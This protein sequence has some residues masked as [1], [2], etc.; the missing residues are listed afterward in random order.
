[1]IHL[2]RCPR[3]AP[4]VLIARMAIWGFVRPAPGKFAKLQFEDSVVGL[5]NKNF[6]PGDE[7]RILE[8][9]EIPADECECHG[10]MMDI[11]RF[12]E[13]NP[14]AD[15]SRLGIVAYAS[16]PC[17]NCRTDAARLLLGQ[18]VAPGW[19]VDECRHDS[20]EEGRKLFAEITRHPL[21]ESESN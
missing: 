12:L 14:D 16:T 5:F 2:P 8:V 3:V 11:I 7:Q 17:E 10:L 21:P 19:L 6:Q 1:M 20:N 15:S 13:H 9:I 4:G 18:H